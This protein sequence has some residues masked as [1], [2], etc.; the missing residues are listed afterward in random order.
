LLLA[1]AFPGAQLERELLTRVRPTPPQTGLN[2]KE[3]RENVKRAFAVPRLE[4]VKGKKVLLIDDVFTTGA[5]V[6]E[7]ARVLRRAGALQVDV[8]TVAR[9]RYE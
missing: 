5:T 6:K 3:R 7:C 8:L 1:Q 2:P 9:V 4:V